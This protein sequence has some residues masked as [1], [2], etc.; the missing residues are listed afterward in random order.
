VLSAVS[1]AGKKCEC[2]QQQCA[3]LCYNW[4]FSPNSIGCFY[5]NTLQRLVYALCVRVDIN[6]PKFFLLMFFFYSKSCWSSMDIFHLYVLTWNLWDFPLFY[7]SAFLKN[8]LSA[9][10]VIRCPSEV[11]KYSFVCFVF[12]SYVSSILFLLFVFVCCTASVIGHLA[13]DTACCTQELCLLTR[14][15]YNL[16]PWCVCT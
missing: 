16:L 12:L 1:S 7:R 6:L 4:F 8:C 5:A 9:R 3:A 14:I 10:C 13:V 15:H 2:I 11:F